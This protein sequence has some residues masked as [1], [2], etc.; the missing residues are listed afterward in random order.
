MRGL[1]GAGEGGVMC[2]G[3]VLVLPQI[4]GL[5]GN[6]HSTLYIVVTEGNVVTV[7]L[8]SN[9]DM[10]MFRWHSDVCTFKNVIYIIY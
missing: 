6:Q 1:G 8:A 2:E 9:I 5:I 10:Q 3:H 4:R 7:T